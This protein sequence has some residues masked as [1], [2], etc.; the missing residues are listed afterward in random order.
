M[1]PIMVTLGRLRPDRCASR[2][3]GSHPAACTD[4]HLDRGG[5]RF[6]PG[7]PAVGGQKVE[8]TIAL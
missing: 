6:I 2:M 8:E 3:A 7:L 1:E 5:R 4:Y